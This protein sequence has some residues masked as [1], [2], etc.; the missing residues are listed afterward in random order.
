MK[1]CGQCAAQLAAVCP[2]CGTANPPENKFCGQCATPLGTRTELRFQS[3]E[4]YTPRHLA[5]KILTS[6]SALEGERKHVTVLFADLKG[7]MELLADRDPEEARKLLDPVLERMMEAVHRYEGTVNQ[8]MGDGVMAL[9]GAPVSHEDHAVRACY[10]ALRMQRRVN[11]YADEIQRGGGTPVQIRVGLNSGEVVVRSIGSDLH[12]DYT[13]VGQTTHLAARMEQMAKPGSVLVTGDTLKLAEGFVQ[14]RPLGTVTVKGLETPAQ[15]Y[16]LTGIGP[17]R[18]RLQAMAAR[19]LTRF[20]GRESQLQHLAQALERAA[21]GHGQIVAVVG[22]AGVGKSRLIW[23]F[24][25]SHR[26]HGWLLLESRSV[27]YGRATSYLP[28]IDLLKAYLRI[29]ER[30]DRRE[31]RE[32]VAGKLLM[33]DR[34]L[35][36][37]VTPLLALLDVPIDDDAW[38]ALD[39][40]KRRARTLEAVKRVLL[41]E[42]QVQPLLVI[43]E[44]LH[45]ID[46]ETQAFLDSLVDSLPNARVLLIVNYR[47]EYQHTWGRKSYYL[48][49]RIDPLPPDSA[50][51]LL[52]ALL[53][54]DR[55]LEPLK[56]LLIARTEGNPFFLE[57][58][59]QTLVET[60][61]L[62]GERGAYRMTKAPEV[63]QIPATAQAILAARIDRLPPEEKRLLQAASVIGKDVPFTLLRAIAEQPEEALRRSL[64]DLQ[65]GEFLYETSLFP[66]LEYT[67]KHALTHEVAY[68]GLL[69]ERRRAFHARIVRAIKQLYADRLTEQVERLAHH[70][71]HGEIWEEAVEYLQRA[72]QRAIE[73]SANLEAVTH[74]TKGLEALK[75]LP[76]AAERLQ[77]ELILQMALGQ[78]LS[79]TRG[80]ASPEV[81]QAYTRARELCREV[82]EIPRLSP[83]LF[84]LWFFYHVRAEFTK[85]LELAEYVLALAEREED[86]M[87][88]VPAHWAVGSDLFHLGEHARSQAHLDKGS[89]LYDSRQHRSYTSLYVQDPGVTCRGYVRPLWLLGY[90]DQALQRGHEAI[91]L[92]QELAHPFSLAFALNWVATVHQFRRDARATRERAEAL[93]AL[94]TEQGFA[95]WVAFG[96][97]LRG[98]ALAE[99]GGREEG[100]AQMHQGV[101]AWRATGAEVDLPYFLALLAEGNAKSG[102]VDD[103][104]ALI[105]EALVIAHRYTDIYWEPEL[106]RLKGEF[107]LQQAV[108]KDDEAEA[109]FHQGLAVARRQQAKSLELRGAMSL[110]RLWRRQGNRE[111]ARVLLAGVYDWFTE[112]FDTEDLRDAK[113]LLAELA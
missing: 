35:E 106:H 91:S 75:A 22:E 93:I 70:A 1:F 10:A 79:A 94:S 78:A 15:V 61:V 83:V 72:G 82:G 20:V 90:S 85:A 108:T 52:T 18:S 64:A 92:A 32:R 60:S 38:N 24:A 107:L 58:S 27:S 113:A 111:Q 101:A 7:S 105:A 77:Q 73:R 96:T 47:P 55:T 14:V 43:F 97:V 41:R 76:D 31:I 68:G 53:G 39:P 54:Q 99:Q 29:Q 21:A 8:V 102:Q 33:L 88:Q 17:A 81:E 30:D 9:F 89:A 87:L 67:F 46:S 37:L 86:R 19:G 63:L 103:G 56:Q 110:A 49:L 51:E 44:D 62:V 6:K 13:A 40:S 48:Q 71:L 59:V 28:V 95:L 4:A 5:D 50:E 34:A 65:G 112:G 25:R 69:Q 26:T 11:L 36:P 45:W 109:G 74:L 80:Y 16:E 98:W 42:S 100:M 23:E 66:E 2:S 84:G 104:L 3:P 12:M 57:E